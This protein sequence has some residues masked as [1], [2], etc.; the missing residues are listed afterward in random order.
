MIFEMIKLV[1]VSEG[2]YNFLILSD[3]GALK[4]K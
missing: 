4:Q 3:G 2:E 1:F